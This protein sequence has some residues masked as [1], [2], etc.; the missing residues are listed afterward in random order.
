MPADDTRSAFG[1]CLDAGVP[2]DLLADVV[3]AAVEP[4]LEPT[5]EVVAF[6]APADDGTRLATGEVP[7][8]DA[9]GPL[10]TRLLTALTHFLEVLTEARESPESG[11]EPGDIA[12]LCDLVSCHLAVTPRLADPDWLRIDGEDPERVL[13]ELVTE[14]PLPQPPA[15]SICSLRLWHRRNSAL[16][17]LHERNDSRAHD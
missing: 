11:V 13:A 10:T 4:G 16:A 2:Y 8:D 6:F 12:D 7:S 14:T 1:R 5:P 9:V 17:R 3:W 15:T